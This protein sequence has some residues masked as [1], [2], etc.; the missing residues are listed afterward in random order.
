[1]KIKALGYVARELAH[2][3]EATFSCC[4]FKTGVSLEVDR[5]LSAKEIGWFHEAHSIHHEE[6]AHGD[7]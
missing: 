5:P 2:M 1:M 6:G 3:Y 4:D 7:S